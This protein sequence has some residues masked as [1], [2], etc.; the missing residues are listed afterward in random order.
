MLSIRSISYHNKQTQD[1]NM[2]SLCNGYKIIMFF[3]I[4][5]IIMQLYLLNTMINLPFQLFYKYNP[6]LFLV[7]P[8]LGHDLSL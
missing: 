8:H 5:I 3:I 2:Y 4:I 1:K 7:N 6:A